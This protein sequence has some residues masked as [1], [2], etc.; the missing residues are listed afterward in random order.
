MYSITETQLKNLYT[1]KQIHIQTKINAYK[2]FR[3]IAC[4]SVIKTC[5]TDSVLKDKN[6]QH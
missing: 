3:I 4:M 5:V 2:D 6:A 1:L